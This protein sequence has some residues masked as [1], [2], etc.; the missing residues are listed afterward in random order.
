M[1]NVV[2]LV[3]LVVIA[4]CGAVVW[5]LSPS[6]A[7]KEPALAAVLERQITWSNELFGLAT[8]STTYIKG[9]DMAALSAA[10]NRA[11]ELF[12]ESSG[13]EPAHAKL[14]YLCSQAANALKDSLIAARDGKMGGAPDS[15]ST[16]FARW[17]THHDQCSAT[18]GELRG[19]PPLKGAKKAT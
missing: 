10:R 1:K 6:P 17:N 16:Q 18:A 7:A 14:A 3:S 5:A 9:G 8:L 2:R 19:E 15:F 11:G 4:G 12:L 13:W